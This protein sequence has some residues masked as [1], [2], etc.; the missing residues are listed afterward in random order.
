VSRILVSNK[1]RVRKEAQAR[2]VADFNIA[3]QNTTVI[4]HTGGGA[5]TA[6]RTNELRDGGT[7]TLPLA[8][9]ILVNQVIIIELPDEYS[10]STPLVNT[11]G[12]DTITCSGVADTS[13]LFDLGVSVSVSLTSDGISSWSL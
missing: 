10:I 9:S 2:R 1:D 11:T 8:N 6:L 4:P 3:A 13:V 12:A 5:L 7:Y